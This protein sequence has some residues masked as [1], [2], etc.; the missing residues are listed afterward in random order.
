MQ[1]WELR[2]G[3]NIE[4]LKI[5]QKSGRGVLDPFIAK[6]AEMSVILTVY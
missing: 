3:L 4:G 1:F 2:G 5:V 6:A